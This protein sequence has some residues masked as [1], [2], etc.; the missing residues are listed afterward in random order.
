M[1]WAVAGRRSTRNGNNDGWPLDCSGKSSDCCTLWGV[2]FSGCY[3]E[4]VAY[5]EGKKCHNPSGD[6]QEFI[7]S[8]WLQVRLRT[9]REMAVPPHP[10]LRRTW[11]WCG[12]CSPTARVNQQVR[13]LTKMDW[14]R[15]RCT[16][17][18]LAQWNN[19]RTGFGT[20]SPTSHT[21]S[22]R[23]LWITCPVVWGSWWMPPVPTLNFKRW[24][25]IPI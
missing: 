14:Q 3:A 24:V 1:V 4:M 17:Q 8:F 20:L 18:N 13:L 21:T 23:R 10:D 25:H 11:R 9:H 22:Y 5:G 16:G 12:I 2:E 6:N 15:R 19:W 7:R